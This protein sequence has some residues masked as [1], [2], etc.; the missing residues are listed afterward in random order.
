MNLYDFFL[1]LAYYTISNKQSID[2]KIFFYTSG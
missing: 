1:F 2:Y